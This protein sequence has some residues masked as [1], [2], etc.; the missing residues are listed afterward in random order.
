MK[1]STLGGPFSKLDIYK[2]PFFKTGGRD[3]KKTSISSLT[4]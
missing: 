4:A 3:L 2:C 1:I